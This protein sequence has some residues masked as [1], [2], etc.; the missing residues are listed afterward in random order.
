[1]KSFRLVTSGERKQDCLQ[2][3]RGFIADVANVRNGVRLVGREK[4]IVRLLE[5][6][7]DLLTTEERYKVYG[8][9]E[10]VFPKHFKRI[11]SARL[12]KETDTKCLELLRAIADIHSN[13]RG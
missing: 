6:E 12:Q 2:I 10:G 9:I 3:L 8:F 7:M 13:N 11:L 4:E 5:N 1:M